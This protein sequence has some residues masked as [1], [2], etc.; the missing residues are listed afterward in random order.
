ML[1]HYQM[2]LKPVPSIWHENTNVAALGCMAAALPTFVVFA[3]VLPSILSLHT[4]TTLSISV[5]QTVAPNVY[6]DAATT[7]TNP[8]TP[9][10]CFARGRFP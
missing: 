6:F 7:A 8:H 9:V 2:M 1:L 3:S 5:T 4:T 10:V